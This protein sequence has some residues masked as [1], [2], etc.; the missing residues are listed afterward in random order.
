MNQVSGNI[1]LFTAF[2]KNIVEVVL[3]GNPDSRLDII[4][5]VIID[6]ISESRCAQCVLNICDLLFYNDGDVNEYSV[7]GVVSIISTVI[8]QGAS[9]AIISDDSNFRNIIGQAFRKHKKSSKV[10]TFSSRE[11][12]GLDSEEIS[13]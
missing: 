3:S 13:I 12:A 10:R 8:E 7:D 9:A 6:L 11:V 2:S 1:T 5:T 4:S